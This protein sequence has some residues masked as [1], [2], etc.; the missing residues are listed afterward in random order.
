MTPFDPPSATEP[1][2][3]VF[4]STNWRQR[5]VAV[6]GRWAGRFALCITTLLLCIAFVDQPLA[7]FAHEHPI[8]SY[9]GHRL[10]FIP[11]AILAAA[12]AGV[13]VIGPT[14]AL[15]GEVPLFWRRVLFTALRDATSSVWTRRRVSH[16]VGIDSCGWTP[17]TSTATHFGP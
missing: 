8:L 5:N 16:G 2:R 11:V 1:A 13:V 9:H 15:R 3:V 6:V 10:S 14:G 12:S 7:R 4:A 17:R